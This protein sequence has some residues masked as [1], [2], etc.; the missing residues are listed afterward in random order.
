MLITNYLQNRIIFSFFLI[1]S[2]LFVG[3]CKHST[4]SPDG[5]LPKNNTKWVLGYY[6]GY[7]HGKAAK[8]LSQ[9]NPDEI[10]YKYLTHI[11]IGIALAKSDGS[12]DLRFYH[13]TE[14]EGL[15]W[16]KETIEL[17]HQ[18]NCKALLMLGGQDNGDE[19]LNSMKNHK[20]SFIDNIVQNITKY[21]FDGID[22][23]WEDN[24]DGI[25]FVEL[26]KEIRTKLPKTIITV[27]GFIINSNFPKVDDW[28]LKIEPYID[29]YNV[30]SYYPATCWIGNGWYSWHN[31]PLYGEKPNTPV[32]IEGTLKR[33][34]L[35]GFPKHKLGMGI[36]FYAIGYSGGITGPNQPTEWGQNQ[37]KGGDNLFPIWKLYNNEG[38][39]LRTQY[40]KWDSTAKCSYLSLPTDKAIDNCQ[41]ISYEDEFSI[42]EKAKFSHEK[43]YGGIII[44]T[45]S[46]GYVAENTPDKRDILLQK[47]YEYFIQRK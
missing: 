8:G 22:I 40:R 30:M 41:Y 26:V 32:T 36:A 13:N 27:P 10:N 45:L 14:Q 35:S 31:S 44:W 23:D 6:V 20:S 19:I 24:I 42:Y 15:L 25:L 38:S 29:Q 9:Q 17:A 34:Y 47:I 2:L 12:L 11:A 43:G 28:I 39:L 18:N 33:L 3:S 37:I 46:Q 21:N 7:Q 1:I 16:A 4:E 5:N